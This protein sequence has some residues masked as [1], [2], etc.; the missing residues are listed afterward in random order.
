MKRHMIILPLLIAALFVISAVCYLNRPSFAFTLK[1]NSGDMKQ[2][3][4]IAYTMTIA[5][6]SMRWDLTGT[7]DT[8]H[9]TTSFL[10]ENEELF[11]EY[12]KYS[13]GFY[14]YMPRLMEGKQ[15]TDYELDNSKEVRDNRYDGLVKADFRNI[16]D[17]DVDVLVKTDKGYA[18]FASGLHRT[19]QYPRASVMYL[20][21]DDQL[22][23]Q[24]NPEKVGTQKGQGLWHPYTKLNDKTL[25][26]LYDA[27]NGSSG[28]YRVFE[29]EK[30]LQSDAMPDVSEAKKATDV[31]EFIAFDKTVNVV[32]DMISYDHQL[33]VAVQKNNRSW[34]QVYDTSGKLVKEE[35]LQK[36]MIFHRFDVQEGKL[37]ILTTMKD[38][39]YLK[40][41]EHDKKVMDITSSIALDSSLLKLQGERVFA[42]NLILPEGK[43]QHFL[44]I[45]VFD[46]SRMVFDGFVKGEFEEDEQASAFYKDM[47]SKQKGNLISMPAVE[48]RDVYAYGF[49][50]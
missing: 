39:S 23:F 5:D 35:Q 43:A 21:E 22:Y 19:F 30:A 27:G 28:Q 9:Y 16:K 12:G 13:D 50:E 7:G 44:E 10:K 8:I 18:C 26:T 32:S 2:V 34:L 4:D 11:L 40:V 25:V 1:K 49:K 31:K 46:S 14:L 24:S 17:V 15:Y 20:Q 41:Y 47:S 3:K 37:L 36:N 45:S 29:I 6:E 33:Y 38:K 48:S 42:L